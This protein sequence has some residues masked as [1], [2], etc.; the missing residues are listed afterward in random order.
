MKRWECSVCGGEGGWWDT[1]SGKPPLGC[2][3]EPP[4]CW[5][6]PCPHCGGTGEEPPPRVRK[7]RKA[8]DGRRVVRTLSVDDIEFVRGPLPF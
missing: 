1:P 2:W 8:P 5:W 7:A 6:V 4:D 3:D